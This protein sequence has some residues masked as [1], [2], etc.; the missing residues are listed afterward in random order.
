MKYKVGDKVRIKSIDWY[1]QNKDV[2]LIESTNSY[3]NFIAIMQDFC[4][5][6]M[7]ISSVNSYY[8][9][10]VEDAGEYFWTDEMIERLVERDGKT[11]PYKIGDRVV[12]K[13]KNRCATITDL[14]YDSFGNLSYYINIYNDK[15][16]SI[17]YPTDLLL[18]YDNK[19]EG[20]VEEKTKPKFNVGDR[21]ITDT[22]MKGKIIEDVEEGWYRVEFEPY[23]NI[24]QPNG[25]VPE[26]SMSLVEEEDKETNW[27][28]SKEEMD[29]L[30]GLAYIT[31]KYDEHKEEVI[32][33]LY[34]D[35]KREFFNGSSY[36]NMFPNTENDVR[37]RSTI[38]VLEYA[39]SLDN[40]NQYGKADIDKNIAWLEKQGKSALEARTDNELVEE[41]VG[42]VDKFSSRC[43]NEFNLPEGYIFKDENGNIINATKIIL[44]KKKE[45][46]KTYEECA[47]V[48]LDRASVRND[49]GYKGE[50]LVTLQKLLV[51]RD[52]YWKLAGE[53]MGLGKPWKPD[54]ENSEER[55]YSIVNIGGDINLPETTLTKWILKVTNKILV[56]PT[57]EMRDVFYD[58]FKE[59]I[60]QCKELL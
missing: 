14:K 34:Q 31:N 51:C 6:V 16:N 58:N 39:R 37:R 3:Y 22:N 52:A 60:E 20:L 41:E 49:F 33:R 5:K 18:P 38:Q 32:T 17:A 44:E 55:K 29:V 4:G 56:F 57:E 23:N 1:N 11:Y 48:L 21:I 12:L 36:E 59:L 2:S 46:P 45:Y 19:A 50:L 30:Y 53:K 35:L 40:Y 42:L 27:K 9:D 8:Y 43:V 13:G 15:D 28:P 47:K 10:M 25:I 24:P 7:T 54:W 26:E